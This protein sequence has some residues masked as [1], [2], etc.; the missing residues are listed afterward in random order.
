MPQLVLPRHSETFEKLFARAHLTELP[1]SKYV[2]IIEDGTHAPFFDDQRE[3]ARK[4]FGHKERLKAR[5]LLAQVENGEQPPVGPA[6]GGFGQRPGIWVPGPQ[7]PIAAVARPQL[8]T[9]LRHQIKPELLPAELV[10]LHMYWILRGGHA[11][12]HYLPLTGIRAQIMRAVA[13]EDPLTQSRIDWVDGETHQPSLR[14]TGFFSASAMAVA[15]GNI[16]LSTTADRRRHF[17]EKEGHLAIMAS[18]QAR[19]ALGKDFRKHL[20][21]YELLGS[22]SEPQGVGKIFFPD[23]TKIAARYYRA[24]PHQPWSLDTLFP[25]PGKE[26]NML[27]KWTMKEVEQGIPMRGPSPII[28]TRNSTTK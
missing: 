3:T 5:Q 22:R 19:Y 25:I 21:G 9:F 6:H 27:H 26:N 20:F 2:P 14:A 24:E 15:E 11:M 12:R 7:R 16:W 8:N 10:R 13:K 17:A 18:V 23:D 28:G 4:L 1:V